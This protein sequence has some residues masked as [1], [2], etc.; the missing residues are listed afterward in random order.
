MSSG[1]RGGENNE[2][3]NTGISL[4]ERSTRSM[5]LLVSPPTVSGERYEEFLK[6]DSFKFSSGSFQ[7]VFN[8]PNTVE[9]LQKQVSWEASQPPKIK[10]LFFKTFFY[11]IEQ[12]P[13]PISF[14]Q[15]K[16]KM[17]RT[18]RRYKSSMH[19]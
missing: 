1:H 17:R 9:E 8:F 19:I 5:F 14:P 2:H 15:Q 3:Y 11:S 18:M 12:G 10:A 7:N 6:Q 16:E 13:L 4:R